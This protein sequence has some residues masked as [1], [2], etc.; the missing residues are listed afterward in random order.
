[1]LSS[2]KGVLENIF[3]PIERF[4]YQKK[5]S[6]TVDSSSEIAQLQKEN[7]K[8][9]NLVVQLETC[10]KENN[11]MRRLLNAPLPSEWKF[12]PAKIIGF[13]EGTIL[14]NKGSNQKLGSGSIAVYENIYVGKI[15]YL[16]EN[17][18]RLIT[19]LSPYSKILA[20]VKDPQQ[21]GFI[22]RGLLVSQ[23]NK[24]YLQKI[25]LEVHP[26]VNDL[27]LTDIQGGLPP[28]LPIGK[29]TKI[30]KKDN[31]IFQE[32]EIEPLV[33]Y[34]RISNLFLTNFD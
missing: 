10:Q 16:G 14:L 25:L 8:L 20:V 24:L 3:V 30:N 5:I 11:D 13:N 26:Q 7:R 21:S 34:Q 4:V 9:V 31:D 23:N 28:D 1:M 22:A 19:P 12:L 15:S 33:G 6:L 29:I 2:T 32:A 18:S 27:V 17:F